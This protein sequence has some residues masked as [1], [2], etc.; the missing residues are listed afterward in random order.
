MHTQLNLY[1]PGIMFRLCLHIFIL[2]MTPARR[3]GLLI[4]PSTYNIIMYLKIQFLALWERLPYRN[5]T[6]PVFTE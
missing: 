1:V 2:I 5:N 6:T 3:D 4:M